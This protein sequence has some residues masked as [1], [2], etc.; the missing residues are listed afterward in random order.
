MDPGKLFLSDLIAGQHEQHA[1]DQNHDDGHNNPVDG[2]ASVFSVTSVDEVSAR[3]IFGNVEPCPGNVSGTTA[4]NQLAENAANYQDLP[5]LLDQFDDAQGN[6][7]IH[8]NNP[9]SLPS[10]PT[11]PLND[12]EPNEEPTIPNGRSIAHPLF[13]DNKVAFLSFDI[14]T[15]RDY[16]GIL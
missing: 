13:R 12:K 5:T 16:C 11:T 14:E 1:T 9:P 6:E 7:N 15:G 4:T 10:T 8:A 3:D 2:D